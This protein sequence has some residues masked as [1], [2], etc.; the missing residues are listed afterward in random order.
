MTVQLWICPI[1][2]L[3]RLKDTF[4]TL[5]YQNY[6]KDKIEELNSTPDKFGS[7]DNMTKVEN[8]GSKHESK[9]IEDINNDGDNAVNSGVLASNN[10]DAEDNSNAVETV[11]RLVAADDEALGVNVSSNAVNVVNA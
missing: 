4:P 6:H 2:I 3:P 7:L 10:L 11:D 9:Y 5:C 1:Q 8:N